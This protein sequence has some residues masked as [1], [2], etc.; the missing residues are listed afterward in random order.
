MYFG[1]ILGFVFLPVSLLLFSNTFGL[2]K[3]PNLFG[4]PLVFIGAVGIIL[5]EIGD[6]V[7]SHFH[8]NSFVVYA[9]GFVLAIPGFLYLVSLFVKFPDALVAAL[10]VMIGSFLFVEGISSFHIGE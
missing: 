2:I 3:M 7:D 4:I 6:I 1:Y 8:G 10:P 9:T 5:V